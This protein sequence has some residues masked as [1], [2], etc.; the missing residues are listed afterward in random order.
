MSYANAAAPNDSNG[1]VNPMLLTSNAGGSGGV[2]QSRA[3]RPGSIEGAFANASV[4]VTGAQNS[5]TARL[6]IEKL[7]RTIGHARMI[8]VHVMSG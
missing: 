2:S 3:F 8:Y 5:F 6:V 7:L 1:A 4:L